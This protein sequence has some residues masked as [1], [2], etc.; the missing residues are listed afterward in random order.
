VTLS[1]DRIVVVAVLAVLVALAAVTPRLDSPMRRL[2][3]YDADPAAP[4]TTVAVDLAAI[5]RA[6]KILPAGTTY[7]LYVNDQSRGQLTHDL[8]G[9]ARLYLLPSVP[10]LRPQD[11]RWILSWM[12]PQRLPAGF[13]AQRS[14]RLAAG[15][16]LV[17]VA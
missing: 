12:Q 10:V 4:V 14:Y 5:R 8:D 3:N 13:D 9:V 2:A 11:A 6:A 1:R 16:Y 17:R 15:I 7:Y